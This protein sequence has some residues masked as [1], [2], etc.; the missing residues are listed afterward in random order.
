MST[1]K[2]LFK[3]IKTAAV[4]LRP[5]LFCAVVVTAD[6]KFD[7]AGVG[8]RPYGFVSEGTKANDEGTTADLHGIVK[9]KC[10]AGAIAVGDKLKVAAGGVATKAAAGEAYVAVARSPSAGVAG[11]I[12]SAFV[13]AG[14]AA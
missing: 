6:D 1:S 9:W 5:F 12:I 8:T 4:D 3:D 10:A 7:V 2:A 13:Q 11:T 14:T